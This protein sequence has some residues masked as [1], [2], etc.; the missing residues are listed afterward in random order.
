MSSKEFFASLYEKQP[1]GLEGNFDAAVTRIISRS[2]DAAVVGDQALQSL[3]LNHVLSNPDNAEKAKGISV[4][5]AGIKQKSVDSFV[6][7]FPGVSLDQLIA[8]ANAA[9]HK[10]E[11]L[12]TK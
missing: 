4:A 8:E 9:G 10:V 11:V 3:M 5:L 6:A 1:A 12:G 7:T 2:G